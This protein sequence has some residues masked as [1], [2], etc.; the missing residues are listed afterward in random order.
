MIKIIVIGIFQASGN[1]VAGLDLI[2]YKGIAKYLF[3]TRTK[4]YLFYA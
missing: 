2:A 1:K 3:N 4:Y